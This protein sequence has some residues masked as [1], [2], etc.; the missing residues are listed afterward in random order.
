MLKKP[1]PG[2]TRAR[3][4]ALVVCCAVAATG[5]AAWAAQPASVAS[6]VLRGMT[7]EKGVAFAHLR[8]SRDPDMQI[9]GASAGPDERPGTSRVVL[10]RQKDLRIAD[11]D[12]AGPWEFLLRGTGGTD[13]PEAEWKLLRRGVVVAQGRQPIPANGRAA[14]AIKANPMPALPQI[15]LSRLPKDGVVDMGTYS[16]P[17]LIQ[18]PDGSWLDDDSLVSY[19][20]AFG[21]NGGHAVLLAH[22]G[23]DGR[24]QRVEVERADPPGSMSV[25]AAT[26]LLSNRVYVPQRVDGG[27]I[28][29]RVRI[30]VNY[31]RDIPERR[32]Q[33]IA[34][35]SSTPAVKT[36][37]PR[38][39]ADALAK[40]IGGGVTLH[41]LVGV[42]GK[43]KNVRVVGSTPR[44]VFE[45]V[46]VEAAKQWTLQPP[47]Q[48]GKAVEGWVEVPIAFEPERAA[49][50]QPTDAASA[51][52]IDLRMKLDAGDTHASPRILSRSGET[53]ALRLGENGDDPDALVIEGTAKLLPDGNV[54]VGTIIRKGGHRLAAPRLIVRQGV[55]GSVVVRDEESGQVSLRL[56]LTAS[57]DPESYA[58]IASGLANAM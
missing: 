44:G 11:S 29:T 7:H 4:G 8:E 10:D 12:A 56:E 1:L 42:D 6:P 9:S 27:A 39:P 14:L 30:P 31:S 35:D 15:E 45:E 41:L 3:F 48:D 47:M 43:V 37:A 49:A 36:P 34:N 28:P 17:A 57:A 40:K 22:V 33:I 38:Y 46:S 13:R 25:A 20:A 26:D 51:T 23:T 24:V 16:P 55:P 52:P 50:S 21:A 18:Q 32:E 5:Y 54:D 53:F 58:D 2:R 19:S